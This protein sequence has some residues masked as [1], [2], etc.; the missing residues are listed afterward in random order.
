MCLAEMLG[1]C[2]LL[3]L[4]YR[5]PQIEIGRPGPTCCAFTESY[6]LTILWVI[7]L[8]WTT[9]ISLSSTCSLLLHVHGG[10][11]I[12]TSKVT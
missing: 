5:L 2:P 6:S 11:E 8:D 3:V 4:L 9:L 12:T 1:C 10:F 7:E